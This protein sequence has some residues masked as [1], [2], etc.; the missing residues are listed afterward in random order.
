TASTAT[1][2]PTSTR[3]RPGTP[4]TKRWTGS[5]TTSADEVRRHSSAP[6]ILPALGCTITH[7]STTLGG[8]AD[9][10]RGRAV[11]RSR[12][13]ENETMDETGSVTA[14]APERE[15]REVPSEL[16]SRADERWSWRWRS[17]TRWPLSLPIVGLAL[18][19]VVVDVGT[20]WA[21]IS[22]G[23]LGRVP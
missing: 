16:A 23:Y 6:E 20:A 10:T 12:G 14:D 9:T 19:T 3:T 11:P 18:L 15:A 13:W 7:P 5:T 2:G 8:G 1:P 4:G 22:I 17:W 21:N